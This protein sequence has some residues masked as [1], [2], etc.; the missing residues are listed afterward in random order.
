MDVA[1]LSLALILVLPVVTGV[2][3]HKIRQM[4]QD[5]LSFLKETQTTGGTPVHLVEK[6]AEQ[7]INLQREEKE[8]Q[9]YLAENQ[10]KRFESLVG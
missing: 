4:H 6:R 7:V 2:I 1:Y 9:A 8:R 10:R 5:T 3:L